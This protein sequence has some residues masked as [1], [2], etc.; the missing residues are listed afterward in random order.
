MKVK[1]LA[2]LALMAFLLSSCGN[3]PIVAQPKVYVVDSQG[4]H[5]YAPEKPSALV[6]VEDNQFTWLEEKKPAIEELNSMRNTRYLED[7]E[8]EFDYEATYKNVRRVVDDEIVIGYIKEI[9]NPEF[10]K[11]DE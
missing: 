3:E 8:E 2:L 7:K 6:A 1:V 5:E 4:S 10:K 9:D 11:V